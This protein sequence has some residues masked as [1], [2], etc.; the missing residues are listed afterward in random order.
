MLRITVFACAL[1]GCFASASPSQLTKRASFDLG[2]DQLKVQ[3]IDEKTQG[4]TGCGKR[5]TYVESC[6]GPPG[7]TGVTCTWVI[8]GAINS[9]PASATPPPAATPPAAPPPAT[10]PSAS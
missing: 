2:C 1:S 6:D 10:P 8:N 5:A 3:E 9:D 7:A 4:V